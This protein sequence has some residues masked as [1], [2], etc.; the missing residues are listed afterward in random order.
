VPDTSLSPTWEIREGDA[1]ERLREMPDESVHCCVTSPPYYGLR[2][3]GIEGQLGLEETL[4][5]Y[6]AA[7]VTVFE[8]VRR[9]LRADG[10]L[11]LNLGDSYAG[12]RGAQGRDGAMADRAVSVARSPSGSSTLRGNGH[13]GGGPKVSALSTTQVAAAP[14]G[15]SGRGSIPVGAGYK[16]KDLIGVPWTVAFALRAAGWYL[17]SDIIWAKPNPMP[18]S[19]TD[20]PTSAHEHIFLLSK[21]SRYFYDYEAI[22]EDA[23]SD[24]PSSRGQVEGWTDIGGRRNRRNVWTVPSQPYLGAHFATFPPKLI[25]PCIRA[26]CP[27]EGT[28]LDPF[29]GAGTTGIVALRHIRSYIGIELNPEYVELSRNRIRDDAPLFNT[30]AELAA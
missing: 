1:L 21:S 19:I 16:P 5:E 4:N 6:V 9:V 26:G 30:P 2:D 10:T 15:K 29:S 13:L 23:V 12:S 7:L 20:R 18:E 8:E 27:V 25:N 3:Y 11:W 24:H 17:R 14:R 28:V 22:R